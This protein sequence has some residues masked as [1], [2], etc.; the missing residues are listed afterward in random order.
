VFLLYRREWR[1][2]FHPAHFAGIGV[3][4]AI[5]GAWHIPFAMRLGWTAVE[6]VWGGDVGLRFVEQTWLT[7]L[8]HIATFPAE[9]WIYLLPSSL[10]LLAYLHPSFWR[11]LHA[12]APWIAF[13]VIA[14]AVTF[15][16]CWFVPGARPRYFMPLYPCLAVMMGAVVE[17]L[18]QSV[19]AART[20]R[21]YQWTHLAA[22]F[23]IG[24]AAIALAWW[25]NLPSEWLRITPSL[26]IISIIGCAVAAFALVKCMSIC[27][28]HSI[29]MTLLATAAITGVAYTGLALQLSISR[30]EDV[31]AQV[32]ELKQRM[33]EGTQLYSFGLQ[34]TMFTYHYGEPVIFLNSDNP[35]NLPPD[36]EYFVISVND[37][38]PPPSFY[39]AW[40]QEAVV[41]C[42][43]WKRERPG[44]WCV[45]GR[46]LPESVARNEREGDGA[47][48]R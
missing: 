13:V 41:S 38:Q 10:L 28:T 29:R 48:N 25:P 27:D 42:D 15:P 19:A 36:L 33:P 45:V 17:M 9:V 35:P 8:E 32:A 34:E 22:A 46:R 4:A 11:K 12:D 18:M 24:A 30:S 5:M 37:Q 16:T 3:F 47:I 43:R 31:A 7:L 44:R 40:Q 21:I 23:G 20:W 2:L 14:V 26:A 39:F 6:D 1:A